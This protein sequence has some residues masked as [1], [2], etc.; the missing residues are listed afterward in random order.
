MLFDEGSDGAALDALRKGIE[1][2]GG[3]AFFVAP[4]VGELKLKGGGTLKADGQLAGSPSVLFDAVACAIM[5]EQA[6]KLAKDGAALQWF[7]DAYGHCKTIGY[8]PATK[9]FIL[10]KLAIEPDAGVIPNGEFLGVAPARHW[11]R[12]PKVRLL[13]LT[14][15]GGAMHLRAPAILLAA[16]PHG[17]TA[18][19]ARLLTERARRRRRLCRGRARAA[20]AAGGDP[21]QPGRAADSRA[22]SDSQLPF[23]KLE[24]LESRGPWLGEPLPAAAIGWAARADRHRAARTP[25]LSARSTRRSAA[26]STRSATRLRRAAGRRRWSATRRCCCASSAM[27][28]SAPAAGRFRRRARRDGPARR[29][30]ST[31]T[32]LPTGAAMLWPRARCL[33][34]LLG[35]DG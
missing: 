19:V 35:T 6:K 5:P 16:R 24:L 20:A 28:A 18:V 9:E 33:R 4:K 25:A 12:E 22:R 34:E 7:M 2:A 10:D 30:R 23:A 26:C 32:C 21:R 29:R 14:R 17:E 3:T 31:T 13:R 27:A 1:K 8:C 15:K 11:D